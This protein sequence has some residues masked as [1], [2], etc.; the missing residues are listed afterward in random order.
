MR[1]WEEWVRQMLSDGGV[2]GVGEEGDGEGG[3][4]DEGGGGGGVIGSV[5]GGSEWRW[6]RLA[7]MACASDEFVAGDGDC[8][9]RAWPEIADTSGAA[10]NPEPSTST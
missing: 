5:E 3:A 10:T 6:S 8:Y 4:A 1:R 2:E 9:T 7:V